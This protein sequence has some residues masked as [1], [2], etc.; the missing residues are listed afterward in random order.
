M[1]A[2]FVIQLTKLK[3]WIYN[4]LI[5]FIAFIFMDYFSFIHIK[6]LY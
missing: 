5:V 4:T 1:N 6:E 2:H 3:I